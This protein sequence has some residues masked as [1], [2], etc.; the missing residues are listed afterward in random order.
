[1]LLS[2]VIDPACFGSSVIR[3]TL[4][5]FAAESLLH[6]VLANAVIVVDDAGA[7]IKDL[8]GAVQ[9][10]PAPL[11]QEIG[12]LTAELAKNRQ[13]FL[14]SA[15]TTA[16]GRSGSEVDRMRRLAL[17]MK[18][19]VVI[20]KDEADAIALKDVAS[21]GCDVCVLT[22]FLSSRCERIRRGWLEAQRL[23]DNG[24]D[25]AVMSVVGR[26]VRY[27]RV[28]VIADCMMGRQAKDDRWRRK[29]KW[30]VEGIIFIAKA[31]RLMSP[32]QERLDVEIVTAA[33]ATGAAGGFVDPKVSAQRILALLAESDKDRLLGSLSTRMKQDDEPKV[34]RDRF[35]VGHRRCW[36]LKHGVDDF[37]KLGVRGSKRSPTLIEPHSD[38]AM[39]VVQE[40][41]Q[42][43]EAT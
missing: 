41:Q 25:Q 5:R 11:G 14:A 39:R 32:Y 4:G 24:S 12:I 18:A 22:E 36:G 19:D 13:K 20:C 16:L 30:F 7:F 37:G 17:D 33:G 29:L 26:A 38:A 8:I 31:W 2:I 21:A 34:F 28:I 40:V 35:M 27:A 23:D 3:D 15:T 6:A 42:L 43:P 10:L 9:G 1:M